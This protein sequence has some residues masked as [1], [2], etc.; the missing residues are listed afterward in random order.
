MY[1]Q[2]YPLWQ[3]INNSNKH[4]MIQEDKTSLSIVSPIIVFYNIGTA[5]Q[6]CITSTYTISTLLHKGGCTNELGRN[7]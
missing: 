6:K 7:C 4:F 3:V 1:L 2:N 5:T